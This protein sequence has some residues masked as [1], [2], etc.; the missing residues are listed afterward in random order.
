MRKRGEDSSASGRRV[1]S[2]RQWDESEFEVVRALALKLPGVEESTSYG[3]PSWKLKKK[4]LFCVAINK[5]AEPNTLAVKIDPDERDALIAT[6]P[7]RYYLTDHYQSSEMVL[8]RL[9]RV[10]LQSLQ[11]LLKESWRFVN[12]S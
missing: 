11:T 3:A 2:V 5:S 10:D 4:L 1:K 7:E 8:I 6:E 9:S 12:D